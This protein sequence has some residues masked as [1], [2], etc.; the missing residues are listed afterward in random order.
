MS[1]M[2]TDINNR[3]YINVIAC[4]P[5]GAVFLR[6]F[7]RSSEKKT[8]Y[9]L[10][11]IL[12]SVITEI[13]A[14]NVVQVIFDNASNYGLAGNLL[15]ET[16]PHIIKVKCVAHGVQLLLKDMHDGVGWMKKIFE[17]S[18]CI[19]D[20][21]HSHG[22]ITNLL[23]QYTDRELKK[24]VK[25][26]FASKFLMLQSVLDAEEGLRHT[27]AS[28]V[29]RN[30]SYS[31]TRAAK[32]TVDIIQDDEFWKEGKELV[33]FLEPLVRILRLADGDGSTGREL[34]GSVLVL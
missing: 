19:V 10:R 4:S 26:R 23:R 15:M 14:E 27:V 22:L 18:K 5:K 28:T 34:D 9:F 30:F 31:K 6:S 11:D 8:G 16:Y 29:W 1:D 20:Y 32:D 21:M 13:G 2:W 33:L 3:S 7:E 25:T 12:E 17:K 24:L